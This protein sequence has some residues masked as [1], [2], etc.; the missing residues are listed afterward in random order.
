MTLQREQYFVRLSYEHPDRYFH[1]KCS[2]QR[3][4]VIL[5]RRGREAVPTLPPDSG[6]ARRSKPAPRCW[7]WRQRYP[8]AGRCVYTSDYYS[9]VAR[10]HAG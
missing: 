9:A 6:A 2:L 4:A 5:L 10:L 8:G 7:A 3:A 1:G